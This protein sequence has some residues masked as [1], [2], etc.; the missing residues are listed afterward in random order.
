MKNLTKA[1]PALALATLII[2][3]PAAA[4]VGASGVP[5]TDIN[6]HSVSTAAYSGA[7]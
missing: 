3:G 2:S 5:T 4:S 6:I 1:I 7:N